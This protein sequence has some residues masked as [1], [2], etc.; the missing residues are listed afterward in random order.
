MSLADKRIDE[1]YVETLLFSRERIRVPKELKENTM[2][3]L[4]KLQEQQL[5]EE[6]AQRK[7]FKNIMAVFSILIFLFGVLIAQNIHFFETLYVVVKSFSGGVSMA[8]LLQYGKYVIL[9]L[10]A[11]PAITFFIIET[12]KRHADRHMG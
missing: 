2:F 9:S 6:S 12:R 1:H 3:T 5:M 4:S 7:V 10:A 11:V 8:K